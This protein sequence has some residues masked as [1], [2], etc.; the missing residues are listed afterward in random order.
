MSGAT[1]DVTFPA[2]LRSGVIAIRDGQAEDAPEPDHKDKAEIKGSLM[3]T[4]RST[5]PLPTVG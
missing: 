3:S 4:A 1:I 2:K 5:P